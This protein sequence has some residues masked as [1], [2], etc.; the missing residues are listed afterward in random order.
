MVVA[1]P[2]L[3]SLPMEKEG[4]AGMKTRRYLQCS[5]HLAFNLWF[6]NY[7]SIFGC[8]LCEV[9]EIVGIVA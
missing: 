4:E 2:S 5:W 7:A 8:V 6:L 1:M 3:R 9:L